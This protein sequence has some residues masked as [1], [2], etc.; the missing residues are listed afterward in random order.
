MM[1]TCSLL[2]NPILAQNINK[3]MKLRTKNRPLG[4]VGEPQN[5]GSP[6]SVRLCA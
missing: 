6:M 2:A 1:H 5:V 4:L 3:L